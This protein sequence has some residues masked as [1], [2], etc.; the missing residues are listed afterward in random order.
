MLFFSLLFVHLFKLDF[1]PHDQCLKSDP[2]TQHFYFAIGLQNPGHWV[3][4]WRVLKGMLK[5]FSVNIDVPDILC[6]FRRQMDMHLC[7]LQMGRKCI[8]H[9]D[10]QE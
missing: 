5:H 2:I 8:L 10:T 4:P 9:T 1:K 7:M 6:Y 3:S